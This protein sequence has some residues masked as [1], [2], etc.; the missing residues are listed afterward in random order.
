MEKRLYGGL[1]SPLWLTAFSQFVADLT[2]FLV[3]VAK[4]AA[5]SSDDA[6]RWRPPGPWRPDFLG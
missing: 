2:D 5:I 3:P 6:V 4:A 1:A